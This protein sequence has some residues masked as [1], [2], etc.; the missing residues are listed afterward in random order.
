MFISHRYLIA[1]PSYVE[2]MAPLE[3][4][5]QI[6]NQDCLVY[7]LPGGRY[8]WRFKKGDYNE[9]IEITPRQLTNNGIA[10]RE[11]AERGEGIA[12]LDDYTVS[13]DIEKGKLIRLLPDYQATNTAFVRGIYAT[14]LDT[15]I[16]PT[17][18]RL[19]LIL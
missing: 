5:R 12:L 11:L 7:W 4:P 17:K 16:I 8:T 6:L 2:K 18:I 10:L 3:H 13:N 14:T 19:F 9:R 15:P 1:S